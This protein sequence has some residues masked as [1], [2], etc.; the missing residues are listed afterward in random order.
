MRKNTNSRSSLALPLIWI[1]CLVFSS[2]QGLMQAQIPVNIIGALTIYILLNL[3]ENKLYIQLT[4]PKFRGSCPVQSSKPIGWNGK[5]AFQPCSKTLHLSPES[6]SSGR[7][8]FP[9][10]QS[11][12]GKCVW[13][14]S[15][16]IE[17]NIGSIFL[18]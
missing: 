16:K 12:M 9:Q 15:R 8:S 1:F 10:L 7:L 18:Q 3:L 17:C 2:N 14:E 4:S 6:W 11:K 5:L 13:A